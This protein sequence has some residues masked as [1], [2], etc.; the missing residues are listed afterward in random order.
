ME[1]KK[2][3][4]KPQNSPFH[5]YQ[6]HLNNALKKLI[7]VP[8][9]NSSNESYKLAATEIWKQYLTLEIK[10]KR[11]LHYIFNENNEHVINDSELHTYGLWEI[12]QSYG[13]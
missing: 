4:Q 9:F 11:I 8:E 1:K 13:V 2:K 12:Y 10:T 6:K 3:I 5:N 7:V